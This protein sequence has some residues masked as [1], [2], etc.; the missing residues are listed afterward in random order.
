MKKIILSLLFFCLLINF[1]QISAQK[2]DSKSEPDSLKNI[3]LSG[4]KFRGIGPAITGGRVRHI[5]VN[6]NNKS[7]Y[8]IASGS[9]SLWKTENRGVT[10]TPSFEGNA[11]YAIGSFAIDPTNTKEPIA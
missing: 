10:F 1:E 8:Y 4:L 5:V 7:E 11:T 2:K 6:P 3:S 9:G